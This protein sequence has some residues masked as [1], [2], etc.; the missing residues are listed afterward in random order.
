MMVQFQ[1]RNYLPLNKWL[2]N[3]VMCVIVNIGWCYDYYT[4]GDVS[5]KYFIFYFYFQMF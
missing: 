5:Y 1:G 3:S 4:N 2:Q